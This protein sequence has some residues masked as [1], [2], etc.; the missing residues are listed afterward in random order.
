[1]QFGPVQLMIEDPLL[2]SKGKEITAPAKVQEL[3][4]TLLII[5]QEVGGSSTPASINNPPSPSSF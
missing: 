2:A 5:A 4:A 3:A 1:M